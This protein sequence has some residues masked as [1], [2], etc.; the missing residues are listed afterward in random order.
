MFRTAKDVVSEAKLCENIVLDINCSWSRVFSVLHAFRDTS[1]VNTG[2]NKACNLTYIIQ[3]I[4][5]N[6]LI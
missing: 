3:N 1:T 2:I 4:S 5:Y 6:G